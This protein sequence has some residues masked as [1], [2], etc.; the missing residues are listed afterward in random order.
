MFPP[1]IHSGLLIELHIYR[2]YTLCEALWTYVHNDKI[3]GINLSFFL[4]PEK[5]SFI[6]SESDRENNPYLPTRTE[7]QLGQTQQ[8]GLHFLR[9]MSPQIQF[10]MT[11]SAF[12]IMKVTKLWRNGTI[13]HWHIDSVDQSATLN[14]V[15][16]AEN[17]LMSVIWPCSRT[18][19]KHGACCSS[20]VVSLAL[21]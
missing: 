10:E 6:S 7:G 15:R 13:K 5:I 12:S 1:Y 11:P 19:H 20:R 3:R 4:N 21:V 8:V 16:R 18:Q 9:S 14:T 2:T 17:D